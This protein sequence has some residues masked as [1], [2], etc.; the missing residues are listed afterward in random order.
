MY[1]LHNTTLVWLGN[2]FAQ[3]RSSGIWTGQSM[4]P[5]DGSYKHEAKLQYN[6]RY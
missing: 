4:Y 3:F 5:K 1:F 6:S 2:L